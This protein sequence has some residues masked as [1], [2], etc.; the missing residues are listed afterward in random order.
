VDVQLDTAETID[1]EKRIVRGAGL[2]LR[3]PCARVGSRPTYF[4]VQDAE[5][6]AYTLWSYDDAVRLRER[7]L[8]CFRRA[9]REKNPE[10]KKRLLT[11]YIVGA[12]FTGVEMTGDWRNTC[13]SCAKP[14]K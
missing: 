2:P 8:D 5:E 13:R 1:F 11:F 7:I 12:G 10:E 14:L 9:S 4:G 3:L 6:H